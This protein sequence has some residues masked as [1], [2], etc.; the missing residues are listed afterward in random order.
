[1]INVKTKI[2]KIQIARRI[3]QLLGLIFLPGIFI[4]TFIGLKDIYSAILSENFSFYKNILQAAEVVTII[5]I[6]II[7][8]RFFCG[9]LCTFGVLNDFIYL[10]SSKVFKIK[11]RINEKLDSKLKYL[12]Y[13]I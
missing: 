4:L 5:P 6:T 11:F 1:M 9:W 3:L 12:K 10:V 7:F 2:S 8:G 13:I